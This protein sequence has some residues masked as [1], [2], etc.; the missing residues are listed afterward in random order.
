M[1]LTVPPHIEEAASYA[2]RIARAAW[3][4]RGIDVPVGAVALSSVWTLGIGV[5]S[6]KRLNAP[7]LHAEIYAILSASL[8]WPGSSIDTIVST[9]EPCRACRT[10]IPRH[11]PSVTTVYY[12]LPREDLEDLGLVRRYSAAERAEL[13]PTSYEGIVLPLEGLRVEMLTLLGQLTRDHTT[14][15]T[16]VRKNNWLDE[17]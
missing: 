8:G 17:N 14:G 12:L 3:E 9:M 16:V 2:V 7:E 11:A 5:A 13:P 6:D 4:Q 15:E 1:E 10:N